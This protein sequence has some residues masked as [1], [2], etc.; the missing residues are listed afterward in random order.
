MAFYWLFIHEL[1][2]INAIYVYE[3]VPSTFYFTIKSIILGIRDFESSS[4]K[5]VFLT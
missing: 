2:E 4:L 1:K 3:A 5:G